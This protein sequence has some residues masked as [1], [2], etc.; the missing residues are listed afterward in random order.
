MAKKQSS[1]ELSSLAAKVLK[2]KR[3]TEPEITKL[4]AS[5]LSQDETQQIE[6]INVLSSERERSKETIMAQAHKQA[7]HRKTSVKDEPTDADIA[8]PVD[9]TDF[10]TPPEEP[11]VESWGDRQAR[12]AREAEKRDGERNKQSNT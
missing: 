5:V 11:V 6:S 10:R 4:A 3:P 8:N 9:A 12:E 7:V 1:P 2:G